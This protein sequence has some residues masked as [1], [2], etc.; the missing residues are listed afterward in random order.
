MY[1]KILFYFWRL[2]TDT[3]LTILTTTFQ[4]SCGVEFH[5]L[6]RSESFQFS[7]SFFFFSSLLL[8][9]IYF[10][11]SRGLASDQL[12]IHIIVRI[13][14]YMPQKSVH[15]KCLI[16]LSCPS[17]CII[18][19]CINLYKPVSWEAGFMYI[20]KF[21]KIKRTVW[22]WNFIFYICN[23]W[24]ESHTYI[25]YLHTCFA[26]GVLDLGVFGWQNDAI[27]WLYL[28]YYLVFMACDALYLLNR[29]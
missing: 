26:F 5:R 17:V 18:C 21:G 29:L 9:L 13:Y 23:I 10:F 20:L 12:D 16:G 25:T 22:L 3:H 6:L 14:V 19:G 28:A 7:F 15:R 2:L 11:V 27:I 24:I 4:L 8:F 1:D